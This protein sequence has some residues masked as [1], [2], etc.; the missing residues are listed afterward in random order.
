MTPLDELLRDESLDVHFQPIFSLRQKAIVGLEALARPKI[1]NVGEMFSQA[2]K[3]DCLLEL[4]RLCRRKA[5]ENYR[6]L[7]LPSEPR[8]LLFFNFEASII[9]DGIVGSGAILAAVHAAGLD[10]RDIVIEI[11]ESKVADIGALKR[12][13]DHHRNLGFLIALDDLGAGHSNLPRIVQLRPH[14]IKLDRDLIDGIDRDFVKQETMKSLV[15]LCKSIG[16]LVLAEGVEKIEEVD[17]C[18]ALGA[19]L[20]QGFYFSR[21]KPPHALDFS[22]LQPSLLKASSRLRKGLAQAMQARRLESNR[23]QYMVDKGRKLLLQNGCFDTALATLVRRDMNIEACYLLDQN[24][25][26]IS[27][28]HLGYDIVVPHTHLFAPAF[29]GTDHSSKEYFFSLL[30]CGLDRYTTETYISIATG[31]LCRTVSVVLNYSCHEKYVLCIDLKARNASCRAIAR[32]PTS[33]FI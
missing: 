18:A 29:R 30:D 8:P 23:I 24:G 4:D 11:N 19:E 31:N 22:V 21:P 17:T 2:T 13:V 7:A 32:G 6:D 28:T 26:Q 16:S 33:L 10:P 14:I 25:I 3:A 20:F 1:M 27:S 15:G 5:M 12:F 9:D